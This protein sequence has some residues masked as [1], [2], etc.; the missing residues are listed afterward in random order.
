[1]ISLGIGDGIH[2][3]IEKLR[4]PKAIARR[5]EIKLPCFLNK[6]KMIGTKRE[7]TDSS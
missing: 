5:A 4:A 6:A 3:N 2:L 1:M 7:L